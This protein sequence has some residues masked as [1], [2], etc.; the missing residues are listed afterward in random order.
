MQS[1]L[2]LCIHLIYFVQR[3]SRSYKLHLQ[4]TEKYIVGMLLINMNEA[5]IRSNVILFSFCKRQTVIVRISLNSS[6]FMKLNN[7][8]TST[9]SGAVRDNWS[10]FVKYIHQ[11]MLLF[12]V[13]KAVKHLH[14]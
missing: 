3:K 5:L 10:K 7:P 11:T 6:I 1:G 14:F 8:E 13:S 9:R 4:T 2:P 12:C